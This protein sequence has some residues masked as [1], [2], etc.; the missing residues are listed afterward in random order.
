MVQKSV[1]I[2]FTKS[3]RRCGLGAA[4]RNGWR[5]GK[6]D[7]VVFLVKCGLFHHDADVQ[8]W[9]LVRFSKRSMHL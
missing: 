1:F 5:V 2:F 3:I 6:V 8:I 7:F 4:V 9:Q